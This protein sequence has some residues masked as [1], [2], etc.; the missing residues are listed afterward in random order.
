[1]RASNLFQSQKSCVVDGVRRRCRTESFEIRS[2]LRDS[3]HYGDCDCARE[4]KHLEW[5]KGWLFQHP[6]EE[7]IDHFDKKWRRIRPSSG[8]DLKQHKRCPSEVSPLRGLLVDM[9]T[10]VAAGLETYKTSPSDDPDDSK[11]DRDYGCAYVSRRCGCERGRHIIAYGG[12]MLPFKRCWP[13][14]IICKSLSRFQER[15]LSKS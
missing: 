14:P 15:I 5:K 8:V 13:K 2:Q 7:W 4:H 6:R 1:M 9:V 3:Y 10:A 11:H 12:T